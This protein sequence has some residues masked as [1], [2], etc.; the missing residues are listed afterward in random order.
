[1]SSNHT[2]WFDSRNILQVP[3][4][5]SLGTYNLDI[6]NDDIHV[7]L[8][9]TSEVIILSS[10]SSNVSCHMCFELNSLRANLSYSSD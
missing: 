1:M 8:P 7:S 2:T 9:L 4:E 3:G 10:W 6:L 5:R